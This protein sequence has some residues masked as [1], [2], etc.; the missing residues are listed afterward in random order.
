[1]TLTE[2][3]G[4]VGTP[5][6]D[7]ALEFL[8]RD[9]AW[10]AYPLGYLDQAS[11]TITEAFGRPGAQGLEA[12]VVVAHLPSL[13]NVFAGGDPRSVGA[14][15]E[16]MPRL[17]ASGVFSARAEVLDAMERHLQVTTAYRMRRMRVRQ[18]ELRARFDGSP[19]RL[20]LDHLE[21]VRRL[22]GLW[23]DNHQL[24]AQL[25][26][27]VYYGVFEGNQ[28]VAAAGTH[29]M[30]LE[31]GIGAIGNVLTHVSHRGRGLA[32]STTTAVAL[33][34]FE[35]GCDEV[36]LNVRQGNDIALNTYYRLG[37]IDYCTFIEGVF[38]RR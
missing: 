14:I 9:R 16:A 6:R 20:T 32:S 21:D 12:L 33:E 37:F 11:G 10:S 19:V 26:G 31:S 2:A 27:G 35:R 25:S 5:D 36:V 17:P 8:R 22:Y 30:S 7:Q 18:A 13:L 38:H 4:R 28:L 15:L 3:A 29:A 24:P 1:M 34:L 23:T